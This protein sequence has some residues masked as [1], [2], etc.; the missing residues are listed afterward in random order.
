MNNN[1]QMHGK[2]TLRFLT[3]CLWLFF[4]SC[5]SFSGD[6]ETK[7]TWIVKIANKKKNFIYK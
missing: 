5:Q 3:K 6:N 2:I 7:N 4:F 1:G